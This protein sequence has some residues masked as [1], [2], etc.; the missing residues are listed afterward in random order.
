MK[1]TAIPIAVAFGVSFTIV[2]FRLAH[3]ALAGMGVLGLALA[4]SAA[5]PGVVL[6]M[7]V[8][9]GLPWARP[10]ALTLIAAAFV[11][12][13]SLGIYLLAC[14]ASVQRI[15]LLAAMLCATFLI[16]YGDSGEVAG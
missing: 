2:A 5:S 9:R 8:S 1:K 15:W 16:I 11:G 13:V 10:L 14:G 12:A 6:V 7:G 3:A 4:A